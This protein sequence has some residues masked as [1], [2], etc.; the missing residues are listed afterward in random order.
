VTYEEFESLTDEEQSIIV[1]ASIIKWQ[2]KRRRVR[3]R[4]RFGETYA[5]A[6]ARA[7]ERA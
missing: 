6:L 5:D 3:V 7:M 1:E 2:V 4:C